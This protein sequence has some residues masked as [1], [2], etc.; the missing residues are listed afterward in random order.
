MRMRSLLLPLVVAATLLGTA[1]PARADWVWRYRNF[2]PYIRRHFYLGGAG[3]GAF[4]VNETG[5]HA[6][7]GNG[8]GFDLFAGIRI[9]HHFALEFGWQPTFHTVPP[10]DA[11]YLF[12]DPNHIVGV[13]AFTLD[14]KIYLASNKVQPYLMFGAGAYVMGDRFSILATGGGFQLGFGFDFWF[15]PWFSLGLKA[16]YRG[17]YLGG[18]DQYGT[19]QGVD[20]FI[21]MI[22]AALDLTAHF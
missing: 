6:F 4:V 5:N 19:N 21:S 8:G 12:G 14:G 11:T 20:T 3:V 17:I 15:N 16:Q 1:S 18:I 7:V 22:T 2:D 13:E 9:F 10:A